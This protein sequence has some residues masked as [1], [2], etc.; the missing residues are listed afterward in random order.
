MFS[1]VIW[2]YLYLCVYIFFQIIFHYRLLQ[3][4]EYS[5]M[6]YTVNPYHL[7]I[8]C[9]GVVSVNPMLVIYPSLPVDSYP[10]LNSIFGGSA[11]CLLSLP[12]HFPL[13][14]P[15]HSD[16]CPISPL[17]FLLQASCMT[18]VTSSEGLLVLIL[19]WIFFFFFSL[20]FLFF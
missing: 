6:C 20:F 5:S 10:N 8:L 4:V 9:I 15:E 19:L 16:L 13:L 1:K 7:L 3:D 14:I 12:Y 17:K 11:L 18:S 2:L